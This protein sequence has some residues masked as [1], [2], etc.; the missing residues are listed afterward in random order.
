M[1]IKR[2]FRSGYNCNCKKIAS[3]ITDFYIKREKDYREQ[4]AFEQECFDA[5]H[6][7]GRRFDCDEEL[8]ITMDDDDM[9]SW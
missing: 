9:D 5:E 6:F 7:Y 8:N 1:V 2:I 4:E 3:A